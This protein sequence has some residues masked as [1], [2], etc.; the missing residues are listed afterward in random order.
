MYSQYIAIDREA[1]WAALFA[2]LKTKLSASFVTIGRKHVPP[3]QLTIPEQPA[4]FQVAARELH[5]PTHPPGA[6]TKLVLRGF[7]VVYCYVDAAQ[8]DTG[9]ETLLGETL[10]N[11]L[12]LAIDQA[13]LPDDFATGKFT[14]GGLVTH[15]WIEGDSDMDP[16]IFGNQAAALL[17]LNI[18][19]P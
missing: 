15:C 13:L 14:I 18:L 8:E 2:Y 11:N 9:S 12:L 19:V 17:P 1:I 16:G 4:L 5:I 10:L 3:P 6:P 7:L